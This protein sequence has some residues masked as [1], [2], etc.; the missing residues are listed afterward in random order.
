[1]GKGSRCVGLTTLPPSCADCLEIW[2][3]QPPGT[4]RTC[5]A[6]ALPLPGALCLMENAGIAVGMVTRLQ[7]GQL[8]TRVP[9]AVGAEI[10][11]SF[12]TKARLALGFLVQWVPGI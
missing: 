3:P 12:S 10:F 2:E 1:V 5:N 9:F 8:R 6:I 7:D 11:L 4:V